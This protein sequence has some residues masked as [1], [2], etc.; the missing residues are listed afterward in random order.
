MFINK[1]NYNKKIKSYNVYIL[2]YN[3]KFLVL[4]KNTKS[5]SKNN[6]TYVKQLF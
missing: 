6:A 2:R 5:L 3:F 4:I 1:R